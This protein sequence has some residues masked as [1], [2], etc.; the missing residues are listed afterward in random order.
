MAALLDVL[1][2]ELRLWREGRAVRSP[3]YALL[4]DDGYRYGEAARA[5]A[6]RQPRSVNTRFWWQLGTRPLQPALGPARHSADLVHGHL[7]ELHREAGGPDSIVLAVPDSLQKEQLSLLLGIVRACPFDAVGL[8]NRSLLAACAHAP[9]GPVWH[10]EVQLHQA[11]L[12]RLERSGD[13]L[14]LAQHQ[15]LSNCGL[16]ALQETIVEAIARAF[17]EHTRFDPRRK[18]E[19]EQALYDSLGDTLATLREADDATLEI[20]GYR[21]RIGY[22]GLR[23]AGERLRESVSRELERDASGLLL[24]DP[25]VALLPGFTEHFADLRVL[26]P[27]DLP[28]SLKSHREAIVQPGEALHLIKSLPVAGA[29]GRR[30]AP[31]TDAGR[32][33]AP[34]R[35]GPPTHLLRDGRAQPLRQGRIALAEGCEL[36]RRNGGWTLEGGSD[37]LVN[38][39]PWDGGT[40]STGD[41]IRAGDGSWQLIEVRD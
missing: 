6:R 37:V 25:L 11:L 19:T 9:A 23:G 15:V 33:P 4:A 39:A 32:V 41:R 5:N 7:L 8:V 14:S 30:P 12:T 16:L 24:V 21:T 27:Q 31:P 22:E 26:S 34:A 36:V 35:A 20:A 1:D 38:G 17:V 10:L 13:E 40:L 3:G 28:G 18:A 29:E 2:S